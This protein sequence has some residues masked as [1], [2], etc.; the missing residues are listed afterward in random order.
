MADSGATNGHLPLLLF[1]DSYRFPDV[2][3][4][5]RFLAPD[6]LV[7]LE[8]GEELVLL[9]NSLEEERARKQ[10]RATTIE[11]I[12]AYGARELR[13]TMNP[14]TD[15]TAAV[16]ERFLAAHDAKRIRVP[17]FFPLALADRLRASGIELTVAE[18]LEARRRA[19]RDDELEAD[20][21]ASLDGGTGDGDNTSLCASATPRRTAAAT[22]PQNGDK[23]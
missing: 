14:I 19:K 15:A 4:T 12:D 7:V 8:R 6:P 1:G 17:Q 20:R 16:V 10:S 5:T 2:Y 3:H 18:G 9:T 13:A 21:L 23:R 22:G 11:N